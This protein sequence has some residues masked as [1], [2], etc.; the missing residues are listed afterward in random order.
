MAIYEESRYDTADIQAVQGSDGVFR[1][2]IIPTRDIV[3]PVDYTVHR[4]V[5]GDRLDQLAAIAY[6]DPEFWWVIADAN[7]QVFY[8]DDL[9]PGTLIKIPRVVNLQ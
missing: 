9:V 5:D 2:T 6:D 8:P 7:P 4:V 3:P 1:A